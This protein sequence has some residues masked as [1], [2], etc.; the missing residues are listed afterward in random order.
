MSGAKR[1]HVKIDIEQPHR[2]VCD[3]PKAKGKR[4]VCKHRIALFFTVFPEEAVKYYNR[5]C[6]REQ[7][8]ERRQEKIEQ[9]VVD[10]MMKLSKEELQ[11]ELLN[12]LFDSSDWIYER[13]IR[14][15]GIDEYG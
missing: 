14:D 10:Y 9:E 6:E 3:C 13:F 15:H 12:I 11:N 4:I 1:Y 2:S 7:E 8:A 5:V